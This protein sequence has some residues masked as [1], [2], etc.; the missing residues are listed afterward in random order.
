[1]ERSF[2]GYLSDALRLGFGLVGVV[3]GQTGFFW[4]F[5]QGIS[6]DFSFALFLIGFAFVMS[7]FGD[8]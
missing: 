6:F 4:F 3:I 7:T 1:M 2:N 5:G 8:V